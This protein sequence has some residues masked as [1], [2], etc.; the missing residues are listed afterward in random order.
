MLRHP[1]DP[2]LFP[3]PPLS[4]PHAARRDHQ[5]RFRRVLRRRPPRRGALP[6]EGAHPLHP[7]RLRA[8][9]PAPPAA[10]A[11]GP[12]Q[13]PDRTGRAPARVPAVELDRARR[14]AVHRR[15]G[16]RAPEHLLRA[17]ARRVRARRDALRRL[18][19]GAAHGRRGAVPGV[20]ALPDG[21]R[22][23]VHRRGALDRHVARRRGRG[24]RGDDGH[25][26]RRDP[27]RR[28]R[29]GGGDGRPQAGGVLLVDLLRLATAGSVD[30][31]KSTLIGR[32]LYD[33]HAVLADQLAHV[34]AASGG[35]Q[36]D[37]ALLT[38]GLRAER[39]Q[40]ITIDVAYRHFATARR[41][42][43]LADTPGHAQYTRNMVTGASTAELALVLVDVRHG[44]TELTRRHLTIARLLEVRH[45]VE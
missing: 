9:G 43:I 41:R 37:L 31:G 19:V 40:G 30:D 28:P 33:A 35:D 22:H 45:I 34:E 8:V 7:G 26:A 27:R 23:D 20:R 2:T 4:R 29:G 38:D 14:V 3:Y 17:R 21:G 44:M 16:R 10:G 13:R 42:F 5:A 32:L 18:A 6:R 12:L 36:V 11:V 15:R 1:P 39:E 24:D 25:R